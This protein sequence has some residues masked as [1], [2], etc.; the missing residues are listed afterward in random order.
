M[1][2]D[3]REG[4]DMNDSVNHPEHY[5]FGKF[6]VIEVLE[7]WFASDPLLWQV[8]KY[9]ARAPRKGT[10]LEDLKKAAWYLARKISR[11]EWAKEGTLKEILYKKFT[12]TEDLHELFGK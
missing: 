4:N 9:I 3:I 6:E 8:G 5:T 7:D 10:E 12:G 11:V 1:G 2:K